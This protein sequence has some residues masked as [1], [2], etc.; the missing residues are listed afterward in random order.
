MVL[1][2]GTITSVGSAAPVPDG[3]TVVDLAGA[4]L[5]PGLVDGHVHLGFDASDD[6]VRPSPIGTTPPRSPR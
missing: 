1:D 6:P 4:T 3:A 2:G 5:L